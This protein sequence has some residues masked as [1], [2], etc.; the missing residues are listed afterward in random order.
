[1]KLKIILPL[2]LL[3]LLMTGC[4]SFDSDDLYA[5]PQR[6]REYRELQTAV[7]TA[8]GSGSY[9]APVSGANRQAIQQ[10]DLDGDGLEEVLVFC[11]LEGERPLKL[12]ILR[13]EEER[14]VLSCTLE[15]DG[16]AFDSVQYAQIDGQPGQEILLSRRIGEQVQQFLSVYTMTDGLTTELMSSGY[17]AFTVS[18]LD[19]D[20]RSDIFVL[21]ANSDGLRASA[22]LYR[23]RDGELTKDVEASLSTG[24]DSVKRLLTGNLAPGVPAV[25]VASAFDENNLITDV[26]SL[27]NDVF[28]NITQNAESG[29]SSQT[30]RNYYVYSTDVDG[31]GAIELPDTLPLTAI[32]G[33][34]ASEGQYR[35]IWYSLAADGTRTDK[36]NTYHNFAEGWFLFLPEQ[37]CRELCVTKRRGEGEPAGTELSRWEADGSRTV[38]ATVY[39]FTGEQAQAMSTRDGRFLLAQRGDVCY[40][41]RLSEDAGLDEE[42]LRARFSFIS[43]DLLPGN[44]G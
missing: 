9:S 42:Q 10:V 38:L 24:A 33:D 35:I 23:F 39:A 36:M 7:E 3:L 16:T 40:A 18:D 41:A 12:L 6:S 13:R 28:T 26:F 21:R 32:E 31:D 27:V 29:Q 20:Q 5:L 14:F 4:Y 44:E 43:V 2:L 1:M 37:W 8:L 22:A 17:T 19:G 11:K 15:G 30:V 25:F 34:A